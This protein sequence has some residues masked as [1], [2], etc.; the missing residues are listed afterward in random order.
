[1]LIYLENQFVSRQ[2]A[3]ISALDLSILRG[4]GVTDYL[5]TYGGR[6][7]RPRAHIERFIASAQELGLSVLKS[8][9]EI[10][11]IIEELLLRTKFKE[12]SIKMILTAGSSDDQ[13]FPKGPSTFFAVAYPLVPFPKHY[14][15]KGIKIITQCYQRPFPH[16]KSTQ[17]LPA[18]MGV[19]QAQ[20]QGAIDVLFYNEK[21]NFLET[22][23]ANFFA[24]K[25]GKIITPK[26]GILEGI[27]RQVIL[28]LFP[29]E[30]RAIHIDEI[31][32]FEG[33]FLTSSNK[34]VMP[35][36]WIDDLLINKGVISKTI[37][38]IMKKYLDETK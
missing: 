33:A 32:T 14:F 26:D 35:I 6:P 10:E 36:V 7:F 2:K 9:E 12:T 19:R 34:E 15:S 18:I 28:E 1:M 38:E 17:Y 22:G 16:A 3:K 5:R 13:F 24:V 31:S 25:K 4:Y 29:V 11:S 30:E 20:K 21:G 27:T 23:T 37:R 8:I